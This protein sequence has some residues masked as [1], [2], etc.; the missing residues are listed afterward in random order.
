MKLMAEKISKEI[1]GEVFFTAPV[2]YSQE[3]NS[4]N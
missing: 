1:S 4:V 3:P 2:E